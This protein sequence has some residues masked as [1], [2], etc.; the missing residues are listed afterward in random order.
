MHLQFLMHGL[1]ETITLGDPPDK[2]HNSA[3]QTVLK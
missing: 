1:G 3:D 2:S